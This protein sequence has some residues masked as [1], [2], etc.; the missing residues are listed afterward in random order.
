MATKQN[1]EPAKERKSTTVVFSA[2]ML[3][4]SPLTGEFLVTKVSR[5]IPDTAK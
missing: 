4:Q 5:I 2:P 1:T 3:V